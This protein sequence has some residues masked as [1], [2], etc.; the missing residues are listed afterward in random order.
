MKN[1]K[2]M[3]FADIRHPE[4]NRRLQEL[5]VAIK[6]HSAEQNWPEIVF[7]IYDEPTE[8]LME[9]HETA[10]GSSSRSGPI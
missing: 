8:R 9:E 6:Q 10:T 2:R 5:L 3:T 1:E 4:L 7:L